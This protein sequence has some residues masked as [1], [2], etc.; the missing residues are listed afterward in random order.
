MHL[1][2]HRLEKAEGLITE[3][4]FLIDNNHYN[5]AINRI[6]YGMFHVLSA[7]ELKNNCSSSKHHEL[8]DW[9]NN[10]FVAPGKVDKKYGKILNTAYEMRTKV[11]Y[12]DFAEYSLDE[13]KT[14][15]NDMKEFINCIKQLIV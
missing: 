6:Y 7:L 5:T 3:V 8:L 1:I 14:L 12:D 2:Q 13:V 11:D 9:F 15:Y 4:Q 10:E